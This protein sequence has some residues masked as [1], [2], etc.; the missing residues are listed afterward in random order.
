MGRFS[1]KITERS[2]LCLGDNRVR[3]FEL[4]DTLQK[5]RNPF[6]KM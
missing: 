3:N 5:V 4:N 1:E 6:E 2:L